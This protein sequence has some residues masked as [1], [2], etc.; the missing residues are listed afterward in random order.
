[1]IT[2]RKK[3]IR[4]LIIWTTFSFIKYSLTNGIKSIWYLDAMRHPKNNPI[5]RAISF[6]NPLRRPLT[7]KSNRMILNNISG[8][9]TY[10]PNFSL[11]IFWTIF[12]STA[13]ENLP[14]TIPIILPI[15]AIDCA[16]FSLI[17]LVISIVISSSLIG[18]GK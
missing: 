3:I 12:P 6:I 5:K 8:I 4:K 9:F 14:I 13:P 18:S 16:L 7:V 10:L 17:I 15:S 1:M 2:D 11:T